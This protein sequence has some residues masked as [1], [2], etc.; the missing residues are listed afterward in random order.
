M[1]TQL[2]TGLFL[3]A[4]TTFSFAQAQ[5]SLSSGFPGYSS[6]F[7]TSSPSVS[8]NIDAAQ[9]CSAKIKGGGVDGFP[10]S[11]AQP[12]PW[13]DIQGVWKLRDGVNPFYLKAKVIRTTSNRKILSLSVITEG[14][15]AK[16]IAQGL[17]YVDFSERNVVRAIMNDGSAKYQI[18]IASFDVRDLEMDAYTCGEEHVVAASIQPIGLIRNSSRLGLRDTESLTENVVLKKTTEDISKIC[19]KLDR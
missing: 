8:G 2:L 19:R 15:C 14:N 12:F 16:P 13:S 9:E 17:G 4:L 1:K 7:A 18:K 5:S 10:W 11:I 3:F 6:S